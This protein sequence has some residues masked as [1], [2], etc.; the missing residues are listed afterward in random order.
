MRK[1][2]QNILETANRAKLKSVALPAIGTG[3]LKVPITV[4]THVMFDEVVK[5]SRAC[6]ATTVKDIRFVVYDKD[7]PVIAVSSFT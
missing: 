1:F 4:V 7:A 3:N 6:P 2:L 5:F